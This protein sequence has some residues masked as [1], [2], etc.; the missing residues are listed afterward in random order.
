MGPQNPSQAELYKCLPY[1]TEVPT[2]PG[3]RDT[4]PPSTG[5]RVR[6]SRS[7]FPNSLK[8]TLTV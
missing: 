2:A 4:V 8:S 6:T 1:L 7:G 5:V 3:M